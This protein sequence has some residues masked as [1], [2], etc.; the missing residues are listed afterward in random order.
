MASSSPSPSDL[1]WKELEKLNIIHMKDLFI[2]KGWE[3]FEDFAY[4]T[5][6]P[7]GQSA[8]KTEAVFAEVLAHKDI[9]KDD[10]SEQR[11]CRSFAAYMLRLIMLRLL[12]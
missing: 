6:D 4:C 3:S 9:K 10:G 7:T 2:K 8:E 5:P 1:F 11:S 12:P